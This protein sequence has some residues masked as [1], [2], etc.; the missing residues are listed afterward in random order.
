[1]QA[2]KLRDQM[3]KLAIADGIPRRR[4]KRDF[5]LT[6]FGQSIRESNCDCD[7]S[8]SPSLLQ[9]IYL[10]N[11]RDV[12]SRLTARDGWVVQACAAIGAKGPRN[13]SS[14]D[15]NT[16]R[17]ANAFKTRFLERLH[18][19]RQEPEQR[20]AKL[21][22]QIK[23]DRDRIAEKL[24]LLG[25]RTPEFEPMIDGTDS[26]ASLRPLT[27]RAP[28]KA[29]KSIEQIV[30]EAYL[31]TLSRLPDSEETEISVAYIRESETPAEG[32]ESL[33]W[34]LINTKEFIITH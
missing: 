30:Q 24:K 22:P 10:R 29:S 2:A 31:R 32:I 11:D 12:H 8:D 28:S 1:M 18:K 33:L 23:R 15:T 13:S 3:N 9:S 17:K 19:Y 5:A 21:L 20:Q 4:N 7:R 14:A 27:N 34:A 25:Y 16:E 26:W 6:V